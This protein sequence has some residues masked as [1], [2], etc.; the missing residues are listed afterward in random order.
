MLHLSLCSCTNFHIR[1]STTED[2]GSDVFWVGGTDDLGGPKPKTF[3]FRDGPS[4]SLFSG[5]SVG[6][7]AG[8]DT[9]T[10]H[11]E[12]EEGYMGW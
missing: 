7:W 10:V 4:S 6:V 11:G 8:P 5:T 9:T 1:L 2:D 3:V 12:G